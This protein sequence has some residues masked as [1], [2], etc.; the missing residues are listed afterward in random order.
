M[1]R[2]SIAQ[3]GSL[4]IALALLMA[5]CGSAGPQAREFRVEIKEGKPAKGPTVIKV[6]QDDTI[7]LRI[8]TDKPGLVHVHDY[9][10]AQQAM[11]NQPAVITFTANTA[12]RFNI[13]LHGY[14]QATEASQEVDE[15]VIGALEVR[16]R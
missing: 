15:I 14:G 3:S 5:A 6:N 7:T 16:P 2:L 8:A 9:N 11:P 4:M 13:A 10:I 12:G 1:L